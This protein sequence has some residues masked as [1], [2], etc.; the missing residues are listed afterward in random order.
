MGIGFTSACRGL[1]QPVVV[2]LMSAGLVSI[3]HSSTPAVMQGTTIRDVGPGYQYSS[4]QGAINAAGVGDLIYLR[5]GGKFAPF[6]VMND[7]A[8]KNLVIMGAGKVI[9]RDGEIGARIDGIPDGYH[10]SIRGLGFNRLGPS[11]VNVLADDCEGEVWIEECNLTSEQGEAFSS[12]A[13]PTLVTRRDESVHIINCEIYGMEGTSDPEFGQQFNSIG[14]YAEDCNLS[15][16][17]SKIVGGSGPDGYWFGDNI[18]QAGPGMLAVLHDGWFDQSEG[19]F[20]S[21][22]ELIGGSGGAGHQGTSPTGVV[23]CVPGADGAYALELRPDMQAYDVD[24]TYTE[25]QGGAGAGQC[26]S[27]LTPPSGILG[28]GFM[29][30]LSGIAHSMTHSAAIFETGAGKAI[31]T[32]EFWGN[33]GEIPIVG[34]ARSPNP[35]YTFVLSAVGVRAISPTLFKVWNTQS[36]LPAS[37]YLSKVTGGGP[38]P[39]T[40]ECMALWLQPSFIS[41]GGGAGVLGAPTC[42]VLI[43]DGHP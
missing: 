15:I 38:L 1:V 3:V 31:P 33:A 6:S 29:V 18:A 16:W 13:L 11:A 12:S 42:I 9:V 28:E 26:S 37:G 43:E 41:A 19:L 32:A 2:A 5:G 22:S 4:I 14:L 35:D 27:G 8:K 40:D 10:L 30:H 24:C 39:G 17:D 20:L 36:P 7:N 23:G 25:G 34:I 21:G